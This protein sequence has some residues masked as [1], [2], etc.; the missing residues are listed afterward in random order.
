MRGGAN[1]VD[2]PTRS[3]GSASLSQIDRRVPVATVETSYA[4]SMFGVGA[5]FASGSLGR[6]PNASFAHRIALERPLAE[7]ARIPPGM[8]PGDD[9]PND[10]VTAPRAIGLPLKCPF[11]FE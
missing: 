4:R 1:L 8:P 6:F 3:F 9:V 10:A 11:C 2:S 5:S 7:S